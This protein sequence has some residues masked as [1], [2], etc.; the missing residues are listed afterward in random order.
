MK[1]NFKPKRKYYRVCGIC[2]EKDE[3]TQM[4]RTEASPN[5]WLCF[6]CYHKEHPEYSEEEF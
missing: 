2:E 3:Q 6:E 4:I 5:G 1:K